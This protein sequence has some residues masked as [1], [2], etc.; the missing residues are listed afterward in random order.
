VSGFSFG[1]P[2]VCEWRRD[3]VP[4]LNGVRV[5]DHWRNLHTRHV[6]RVFELRLG[7]AGSYGDREPCVVTVDLVEAPRET[8]G[9][10][11]LEAELPPPGPD[12]Y[13]RLEPDAGAFVH[14]VPLWS[15]VEHYDPVDRPGVYPVPFEVDDRYGSDRRTAVEAWRC[16]GYR[17]PDEPERDEREK[18]YWHAFHVV[19]GH[20]I[21]WSMT[22]RIWQEAV[23]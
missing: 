16:P 17:H 8:G 11:T 3:R 14:A 15:L 20:S 5:G 2:S 12:E 10:L 18:A 1:H 7:G 6:V 21:D 22:D 9:Q 4:A 19:R 23:E 13:E